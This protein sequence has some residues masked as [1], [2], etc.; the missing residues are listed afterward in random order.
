M[1]N[2]ISGRSTYKKYSGYLHRVMKG[3]D[4]SVSNVVVGATGTGQW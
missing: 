1:P 2:Q 4:F 3:I